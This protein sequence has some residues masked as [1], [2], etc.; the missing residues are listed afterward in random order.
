[1]VGNN[2]G[3]SAIWIIFAV[4]VGGGLFG[5]AGIILGIPLLAVC[6]KLLKRFSNRKLAEKKMSPE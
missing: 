2:V 5:M 4:V 6:S 1:M 3:L